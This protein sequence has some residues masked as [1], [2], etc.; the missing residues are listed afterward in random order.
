MN[1]VRLSSVTNIGSSTWV[2]S[3]HRAL[4]TAPRIASKVR[5]TV[6]RSASTEVPSGTVSTTSV[7]WF[8]PPFPY[9]ARISFSV[10]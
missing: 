4:G 9:L 7:G 3:T 8:E 5:L 2:K 10:S 1:V 6:A